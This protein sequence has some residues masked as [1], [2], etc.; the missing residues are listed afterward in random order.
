M[1]SVVQ[2]GLEIFL[3][4]SYFKKS[5]QPG[6]PRSAR[7]RF[8][9]VATFDT[10]ASGD[11]LLADAF[12]VVLP[13]N[14][15]LD[16]RHSTK[17]KPTVLHWRRKNDD[18]QVPANHRI[19][20]FELSL[21]FDAPITVHPDA[22]VPDEFLPL[23][24]PRLQF[25]IFETADHSAEPLV[26]LSTDS[27]CVAVA[28]ADDT[29]RVL[30]ALC[31]D[32]TTLCVRWRAGQSEWRV[33]ADEW[34]TRQHSGEHAEHVLA[35]LARWLVPELVDKITNTK[36]LPSKNFFL[37]HAPRLMSREIKLLE[38]AEAEA[39]FILDHFKRDVEYR[40]SHSPWTPLWTYISELINYYRKFD[41]MFPG[42]FALMKHSAS[43]YPRLCDLLIVLNLLEEFDSR[44]WNLTRS[45]EIERQVIHPNDGAKFKKIV[46]FDHKKVF[47]LA[48]QS[49]DFGIP[50]CYEVS[51]NEFLLGSL[52]HK[53]TFRCTFHR[54]QSSPKSYLQS[55]NQ[56]INSFRIPAGEANNTNSWMFISQESIFLARNTDL[57]CY[58]KTNQKSW[59]FDK[60]KFTPNIS[61]ADMRCL[62]L[63]QKELIQVHKEYDGIMIR[64]YNLGDCKVSLGSQS[65]VML[66]LN[67][68][69]L[70]K[71]IP[72]KSGLFVLSEVKDAA[73]QYWK[74]IDIDFRTDLS[75]PPK[76]TVFT[77]CKITGTGSVADKTAAAFFP[78]TNILFVAFESKA[79][80]GLHVGAWKYG[81]DNTQ[82]SFFDEITI[83]HLPNIAPTS[84]RT[85]ASY[86]QTST[87]MP[88]SN[89]L[90]VSNTLMLLDFSSFGRL[91]VWLWHKEDF[92]KLG[93][94]GVVNLRNHIPI[95]DTLAGNRPSLFYTKKITGT[96]R[97]SIRQLE[98]KL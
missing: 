58:F 45:V 16:I 82:S 15:S 8:R 60:V 93:R 18:L 49:L 59:N 76:S 57:I 85:F 24:N 91:Q 79:G 68:H 97:Y 62:S 13:A 73:D 52:L 83:K 98:L 80:P 5:S 31:G 89:F 9:H 38:K 34:E 54:Q 90:R 78:E 26:Q 12:R 20:S 71:A 63:D 39:A 2:P 37:E 30:K 53:I 21:S 27:V 81:V 56:L 46:T 43:Y 40:S 72:T 23:V 75:N 11:G 47:D 25:R 4:R 22:E 64:A 86:L 84:K 19:D 61:N 44:S 41:S 7:I 51:D 35:M 28:F 10:S 17:R 66:P 69:V 67:G 48:A 36:V 88:R 32:K 74:L 1:S 87:V 70:A 94:T 29:R 6:H 95:E 77:L 92:C 3:L 14:D 42:M 50:G 33:G 55:S 65:K 96:T